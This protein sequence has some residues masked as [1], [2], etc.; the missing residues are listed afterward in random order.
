MIMQNTMKLSDLGT[1]GL[2][3]YV[4]S[5]PTTRL[6][7]LALGRAMRVIKSRYAQPMAHYRF[8]VLCH[9]T[10]LRLKG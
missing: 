3:D 10:E 2:A 1:T 9:K 5:Q 4:A 6:R 8:R 7:A